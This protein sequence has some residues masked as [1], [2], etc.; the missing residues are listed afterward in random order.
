MATTWHT[1]LPDKSW[2][3]TQTAVGAHFL[4]T[5]PWAA[6]Q[7]AQG[8]RLFYAND[9]GWSWL[10]IVEKGRFGTRLYC[11][12]GPTV[13]SLAALRQALTVLAACAKQQHVDYVRIEPQGKLT[14]RQLE[15]LGLVRAHRNIQPHLT[16]IKDLAQPEAALLA[17]MT[18][19]NRN[20]HRTAEKKGLS[21]E[22]STNPDD[23][24]IFLKLMHEVAQRNGITIHPDSYFELMTKTLMPLGACKLYVAKHEGSPVAA[25]LVL[26]SPTTRYYAHAAA[27]FEARKLHPGTPLVSHMIFDAKA[28]G[29]K[30]FDFYG[31][32]P[33][34]QPNHR[35]AGFTRFK[36][37][38]GGTTH[39][40]HGTWELP[41]KKLSYRFY[42]TLTNLKG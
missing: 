2:G 4:Q 18:A 9:T 35:W 36:Q 3:K 34:D 21:F 23:T 8:K 30:S 39:D 26:D 20:L 33:P 12:Y 19:T 6:F 13:S 25:S 41:I 1:D 15:S 42:R 40:M 37:S 5:A 17:E 22:I 14:E 24:T 27:K 29:L 11:P 7:Q 32:A 31:I 38:F 28:A 16:W 10:A